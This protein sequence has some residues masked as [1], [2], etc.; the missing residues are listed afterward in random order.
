[1]LIKIHEITGRNWS[2]DQAKAV[3][4]AKD[5]VKPLLELLCKIVG[6]RRAFGDHTNLQRF[7][8]PLNHARKSNIWGTIPKPSVKKTLL[9]AN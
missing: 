5:A 6:S 2:T 1:V 8:D 3:H 9:A 7:D 4:P